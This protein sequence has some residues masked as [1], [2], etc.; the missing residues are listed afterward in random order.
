MVRPKLLHG[1]GESVQAVLHVVFTVC[2]EGT[3]ISK[4]EV[5]DDSLFDLHNS[6][7]MM[8]VMLPSHLSDI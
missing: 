1:P 8:L 5:S 4:H 2:I 7:Q 3:V 6:F